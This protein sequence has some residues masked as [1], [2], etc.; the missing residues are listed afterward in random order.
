VATLGFVSLLLAGSAWAQQDL[1]ETLRRAFQA[2][3]AAEKAGQLDEAEKEFLAVIRQGGNVASVHHNLGTVYQQRGDQVRAIAEFRE[4]IRLQPQFAPS[5]ILLGASL[6]AS[7]K[8]QEAVR[9]L[10]RAVELAPREPAAHLELAKA[11]ESA[12][13]PVGVVNQYQILCALAP[14]DPEATYQL[15]QAYLKLSQWCVEE[16]RRLAPRSSRMYQSIAD[17]LVGQGQ[18]ARAIH[19][20]QRAAQADPKL[21]GIHLALAQIYLEQNQTQEAQREIARELDL[22]PESVAAQALQERIASRQGRD[23]VR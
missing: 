7:R 8:F 23:A 17:A 12:G 15:G 20:F 14:H 22:V 11:Y 9:A 2:G 13:N 6:L 4:A 19:F 16:I 1:P 18:T 3:V 5:H 21:P 10:E